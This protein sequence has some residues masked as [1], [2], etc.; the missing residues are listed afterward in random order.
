MT[1][2]QVGKYIRLLCYQ[3]QNGR[4]TEKHMLSICKAYDEDVFLKFTKDEHGL[5]YNERL[6]IEAARRKAYSESRKN[7]AQHSKNQSNNKTKKDKKS[8]KAYAK[9]MEIEI[10]NEIETIIKTVFSENFISIWSI[11][12]EYKRSE[13]RQTYKTTKSQIQAFK[14][15]VEISNGK[16]EDAEKIINN[17]IGNH[18]KGLFPLKNEYNGTHQQT[19][20]GSSIKPGRSAINDAARAN[21]LKGSS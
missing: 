3:H 5:Y 6:E 4:M 12:I 19:I 13:L 18:Y 1:D 2:E 11:W 9:H 10:D 14:H 8:V 21:Y 7:N 17:S 15:L 16:S 20:N